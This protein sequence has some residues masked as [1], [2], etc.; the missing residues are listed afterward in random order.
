MGH[1]QYAGHRA[2]LDNE[3]LPD[4]KGGI[5]RASQENLQELLSTYLSG[6]LTCGTRLTWILQKFSLFALNWNCLN[7]STNGIPSMS[8]MVPPSWEWEKKDTRENNS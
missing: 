2:P 8:P 7:A 5:N 1:C 3:W 6:K 4:L